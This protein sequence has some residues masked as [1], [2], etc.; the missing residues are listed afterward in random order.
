MITNLI[1]NEAEY[2]RSFLKEPLMCE[3][4]VAQFDANVL[5]T[6]IF[7]LWSLP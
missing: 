1:R 7:L 3:T 2:S 6:S 4:A 5:L